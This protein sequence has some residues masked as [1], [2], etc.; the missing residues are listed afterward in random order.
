[1]C[2]E[3]ED[4]D[5]NDNFDEDD[6]IEGGPWGGG[7]NDRGFVKVVGSASTPGAATPEK[8]LVRSGDKSFLPDILKE[9][10]LLRWGVDRDGGG[11][12]RAAGGGDG[13][14]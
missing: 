7:T 2:R 11:G 13:V 12:G 1:M 5:N 4:D 8:G 14:R 3:E 9:R 10:L 6:A